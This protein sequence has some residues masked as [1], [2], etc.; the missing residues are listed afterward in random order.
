[1]TIVKDIPT[2]S[3]REM[4]QCGKIINMFAIKYNIKLNC[5]KLQCK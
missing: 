4:F 3:G 5:L 2:H 1:M